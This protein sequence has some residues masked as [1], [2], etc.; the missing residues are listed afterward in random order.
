MQGNLNPSARAAIAGFL[1]PASVGVGTA[2]TGWVDMRTFFALLALINVGAFGVNGT[3]DAKIQ[4]AMDGTG[5]G[6]KD[7]AGSAITQLLAAGGNNRQVA[8]DIRPED[9]DKNNGFK[10]VRLSLTVG[11]AATLVSAVLMG[12]DPRYG[13]AAANQSTSVAQTV[14]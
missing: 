4:Q 11:T 1:P 10:F 13:T 14:S 7:V 9:L 12:L 2:T 3:I 5:A 6:A 8:I